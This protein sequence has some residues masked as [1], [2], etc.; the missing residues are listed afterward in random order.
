MKWAKGNNEIIIIKQKQ[1]NM[2]MHM[3]KGATICKYNNSENVKWNKKINK[4]NIEICFGL[5]P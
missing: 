2:E 5:T 4:K 3:E 1:K